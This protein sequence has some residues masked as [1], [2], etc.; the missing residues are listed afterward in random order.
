MLYYNQIHNYG[1]AEQKKQGLTEQNYRQILLMTVL[2][3]GAIYTLHMDEEDK[4]MVV[5]ATAFAFPILYFLAVLK[6]KNQ[7]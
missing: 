5:A 6:N 1:M 2:G 3:A 7:G 4:T